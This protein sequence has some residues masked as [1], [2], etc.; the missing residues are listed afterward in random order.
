MISLKAREESARG[1]EGV[2]HVT[3]ESGMRWGQ[4]WRLG[5]AVAA[6]VPQRS[7]ETRAVWTRGGMNWGVGEKGGQL[8]F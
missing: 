3:G 2:S 7:R 1:E 5:S 4:E 8:F 6:A